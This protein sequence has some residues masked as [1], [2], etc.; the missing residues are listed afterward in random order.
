MM[1]MLNSGLRTHEAGHRDLRQR[2]AWLQRQWGVQIAQWSVFLHQPRRQ[3]WVQMLIRLSKQDA[4]IQLCIVPTCPELRNTGD[5]T[6][7]FS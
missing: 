7:K 5:A 6:P 3:S 4:N 1:A 2:S